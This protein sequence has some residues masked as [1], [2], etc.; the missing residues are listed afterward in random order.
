[1]TLNKK[2]NYYKGNYDEFQ[3]MLLQN[4]KRGER[5][6]KK[7]QNKIMDMRKKNIKTLIQKL[8]S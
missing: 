3:K 7:I 5:E 4:L 2:L 1:M 6:W 8:K